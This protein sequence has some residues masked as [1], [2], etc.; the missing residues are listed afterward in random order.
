M[1]ILRLWNT[2]AKSTQH[3]KPI[4]R[5]RLGKIL[6]IYILKYVS[7]Q[8]KNNHRRFDVYPTKRKDQL[9]F[10]AK[11]FNESSHRIQW[12]THDNKHYTE[13]KL[14]NL[15]T[16]T[17]Y[18]LLKC[19]SDMKGVHGNTSIHWSTIT[20]EHKIISGWS[21]HADTASLWRDLHIWFDLSKSRVLTPSHL[22]RDKTT[23]YLWNMNDCRKILLT[24]LVCFSQDDSSRVVSFT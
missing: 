4:Y 17:N 14:K 20:S 18:A 7:P 5:E 16:P 23:F 8:R 9:S 2:A 21:I 10:K 6:G 13:N 1:S 3:K 19:E 24:L 11:Y 22:V 12:L 15:K